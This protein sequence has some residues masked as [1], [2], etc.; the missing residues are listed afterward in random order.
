MLICSALVGLL[1]D[2]VQVFFIAAKSCLRALVG[3]SSSLLAHS[4]DKDRDSCLPRPSCR[5]TSCA[6]LENIDRSEGSEVACD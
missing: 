6:D 3:C 2:L 1:R 5:L 4:L